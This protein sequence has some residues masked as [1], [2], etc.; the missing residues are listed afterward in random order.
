M[1]PTEN[2][3]IQFASIRRDTEALAIIQNFKLQLKTLTVYLVHE[4]IKIIKKFVDFSRY[5][6]TLKTGRK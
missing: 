5:T 3:A 1:K 6:I 2:N 4:F